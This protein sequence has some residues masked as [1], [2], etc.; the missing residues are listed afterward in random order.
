MLNVI[1]FVK[2]IYFRIDHPFLKCPKTICF[3]KT[4]LP[5]CP[6]N[7]STSSLLCNCPSA[8]A[9]CLDTSTSSQISF[10]SA[11]NWQYFEVG[12]DNNS[13]CLNVLIVLETISF[14]L[15]FLLL[16]V[17]LLHRGSFQEINNYMRAQ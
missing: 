7:C 15:F 9:T 4:V 8:G 2:D 11:T 13:I 16:F 6:A 10:L 17:S 12:L 3:N 14:F 5:C 1:V